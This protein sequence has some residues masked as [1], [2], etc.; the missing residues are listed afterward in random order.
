MADFCHRVSKGFV[1]G[2]AHPH[3]PNF[4]GNTFPG[5]LPQLGFLVTYLQQCV[6]F[7]NSQQFLFPF[8]S[9]HSLL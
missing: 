7:A 6:S 3:A 1:K 8:V 2:A 9:E 4:S 5:K